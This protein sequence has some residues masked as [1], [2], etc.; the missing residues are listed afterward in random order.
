MVGIYY[1]VSEASLC[2]TKYLFNPNC[3]SVYSLFLMLLE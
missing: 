3:H 1:T 2:V